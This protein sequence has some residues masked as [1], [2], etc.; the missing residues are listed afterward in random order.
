MSIMIAGHYGFTLAGRAYLEKGIGNGIS[1]IIF[2]G[3]VANL[4]STIQRTLLL[5]MR[6]QIPMYVLFWR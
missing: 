3:I 1:L 4:L 6:S 2:G 5:L